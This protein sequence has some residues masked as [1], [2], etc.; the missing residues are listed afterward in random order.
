MPK[1]G[2]DHVT[3]RGKQVELE[4]HFSRKTKFHYNG[5]PEEIY[6]MTSLG[7]ETYDTETALKQALRSA[8]E[9]YHEKIKRT[10]K[11]IFYT[12]ECSRELFFK[13][14]ET[15]VA[16]TI[17]RDK[18]NRKFRPDLSSRFGVGFDFLI[19]LEVSAVKTEYYRLN[20]DG[21]PGYRMHHIKSTDATLIEW[22][23]ERERFFLNMV[24]QLQRL[25]YGVSSFFDAPDLQERI[26]TLGSKL[27]KQ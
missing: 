15:C 6:H 2:K 14:D 21:T 8:L 10:R 9:I 7:I 3:I 13:Q 26:E 20:E 24:A 5:L 22:T 11:M 17:P 25:I 27:L 18:V 16:N 19:L 4:V 23:P 1:I 12:L